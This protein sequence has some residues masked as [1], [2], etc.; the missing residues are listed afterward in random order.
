MRA[1]G[2][3][4]AL[5]IVPAAALGRAPESGLPAAAVSRFAGLALACVHQEYPNKIAHVLQS[6]ADL[7]APHDLTPAFYGCYRMP[8]HS[9]PAT[10]WSWTAARL[11]RRASPGL[12]L[13]SQ[14]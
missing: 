13:E 10:C 3:V 12:W 7:H 11:F 1:L 8:P 6:D 14:P 2:V 4:L 5:L 9:S